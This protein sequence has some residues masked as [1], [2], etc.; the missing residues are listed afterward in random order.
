MGVVIPWNRHLTFRKEIT[1]HNFKICIVKIK[2]IMR[3]AFDFIDNR[4]ILWIIHAVIEIIKISK[5]RIDGV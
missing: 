4:R 3:E 2:N 1:W 5:E